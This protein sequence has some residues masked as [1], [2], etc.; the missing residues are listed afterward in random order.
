MKTTIDDGKL[1]CQDFLVKLETKIG[2]GGYGQVYKVLLQDPN[3]VNSIVGA[4]KYIE[5]S[6]N[7]GLTSLLEMHIMKYMVY[8]YIAHALKINIDFEGGLQIIQPIALGDAATL[9]RRSGRQLT[10]QQLK[11]WCWQ[12]VC[13]VSYLHSKNIVHADVKASNVLVFEDCVKLADY[14]LSV[15]IM[16]PECGTKDLDATMS[17]T[18]THRPLEVWKGER[19]S[20]SADIWALGCTFYELGY[21]SLIFPDQRRG[22]GNKQLHIRAL[23]EWAQQ[24]PTP[25]NLFSRIPS[26]PARYDIS[27]N[28][29][30]KP[31]YINNRWNLT[32]MHLFND[33]ILSMLSI[34]PHARPTIWNIVEHP[35]FDGIRNYDDLPKERTCS[36]FPVGPGSTDVERLAISLQK[37]SISQEIQCIGATLRKDAWTPS[38]ETCLTV[39]HKILYK[40][41]PINQHKP[42]WKQIQDEIML[43]QKLNYKFLD[44]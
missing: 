13:G 10:D 5:Y 41:Q 6:K 18:S 22:S 38:M 15:F 23:E 34:D 37:R 35:F 19:W 11:I 44:T 32:E 16:D 1:L 30:Y 33:L 21:S 8:K 28:L 12:L 24:D 14:S 3:T 36:I 25:Y 31:F 27:S 40:C 20:F 29:D 2:H 43:C 9:V 39:A 42:T 17:Y 4:L 26:T 7:N